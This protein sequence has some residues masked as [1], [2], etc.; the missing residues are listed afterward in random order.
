[1]VAFSRFQ[2][3]RKFNMPENQT[4]GAV[5]G[6]GQGD[7]PSQPSSPQTPAPIDGDAA[8]L[9]STLLDQKLNDRFT[10]FE[11]SLGE[12]VGRAQGAADR[13]QNAVRELAA[14]IEQYEKQ[15]MTREQAIAE[16]ENVDAVE[17]RWKTLEQKLD[18]LAGRIATGGTQANGQ[19]AVAKVFESV[20]LDV[21][22]P[23]VASALLTQYKS[24]DEVEL[25]AYRLSRQIQ[26]SPNPNPAQNP[27]LAGGGTSSAATQLDA[28]YTQYAEAFKNPTANAALLASL[29]KQM[30][31]LGG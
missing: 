27:S 28:I 26:Q 1:V 31:D 10:A 20:G 14:K 16:I 11:K 22:D 24:A 19:Q 5:P 21:K 18:D 8:Q 2:T 13:S 3:E 9:L 25:A 15:G 23:R 17:T 29:E 6:G 12:K 4:V 30:K 7:T